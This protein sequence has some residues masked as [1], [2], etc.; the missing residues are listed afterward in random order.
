MKVLLLLFTVLLLS[1]S[2]D[3][4]Y[5]LSLR[6]ID[7]KEIKLSQFRGKKFIVYVWSGTC[8]GHVED[9]KRL[10]VVYPELEVPLVSI[11]VMMDVQDVKEVLQKNNI[12]PNYPVLADPKGEFANKV[13]LLFLPATIIFNERGEVL[14]NFPQLPPE[15]V[16]LISTHK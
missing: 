5:N 1:C 2:S 10:T 4:L 13:T 15:L 14:K 16:S 6:S 7:G 12:K 3:H 9:L 11:A 8:V